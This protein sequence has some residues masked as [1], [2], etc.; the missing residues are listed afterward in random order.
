MRRRR[1]WR[2]SFHEVLYKVPRGGRR[3]EEEKEEEAGI[4]PRGL[5]TKFHGADVEGGR[6][7]G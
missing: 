2:P 7:E 6:M 5:D 3:E 1:G 4:V